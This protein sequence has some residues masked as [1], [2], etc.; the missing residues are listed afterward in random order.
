MLEVTV[1]F[2][3]GVLLGSISFYGLLANIL[4]VPPVYWLTFVSKKSPIYVISLVNLFTDMLNLLLTLCYLVPI[5][6]N[7]AFVTSSTND[8]QFSFYIGTCFMFCWYVGSMTQIIMAL[9]RVV[10]ICSGYKD[11]FTHRVLLL[12]FSFI[13]PTAIALTYLAQFGFSCC[14]LVYDNR[15][16]SIRYHSF[17]NA[18]INYSNLFIDVPLNFGTS[19]TAFV[20]YS[21]ARG[22]IIFEIWKTKKAIG[23]EVAAQSNHVKREI[24]YAIQFCLITIFYT[25]SWIL[26]RLFPIILGNR[27]MELYCFVMIAVSLNNSANAVVFIIFNKEV[28][29]CILRSRFFLFLPAERSDPQPPT[30]LVRSIHSP[31]HPA[32][33]AP[34]HP[35][36][37][38]AS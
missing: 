11:F 4:V 26:F 3:L 1:K 19:M 9:N 14:A 37:I 35:T 32:D 6:L 7:S 13:F 20:C 8:M 34:S 38:Q 33:P 36:P 31:L 21:M 5:I 18:T 12:I 23:V 10:V 2:C 16:L 29:R 24:S 27:G 28:L 22:K 15:I 25:I 30:S 17:G